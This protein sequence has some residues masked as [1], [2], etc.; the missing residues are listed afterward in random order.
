MQR[1]RLAKREVEEACVC[2]DPK[3]TMLIGE[4]GADRVA[5][6]LVAEE[7]VVKCMAIVTIDTVKPRSNPQLSLAVFS[8]RADGRGDRH[9][10]WAGRKKLAVVAAK[11]S[12]APSAEPEVAVAVG[13]DI[14]G[15]VG[16]EA[17]GLTEG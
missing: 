11:K 7:V 15:V 10:G 13:E 16:L 17:L 6:G 8:E 1:V 12:L 4:Y 9:C 5:G 14:G 3:A 2:S